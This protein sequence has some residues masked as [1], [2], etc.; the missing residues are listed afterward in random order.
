MTST[1]I[2]IVIFLSFAIACSDN[3]TGIKGSDNNNN[4][5]TV[6]ENI[7]INQTNEDKSYNQLITDNSV[8][9]IKLGMSVSDFTKIANKL[10]YTVKSEI[11]PDDAGF[12]VYDNLGNNILTVLTDAKFNE[13]LGILVN[14]GEYHTIQNIK[15]GSSVQEFVNANPKC[16]YFYPNLGDPALVT[17]NTDILFYA[18][19]ASN[20]DLS[21]ANLPETELKNA[22]NSEGVYTDKFNHEGKIKQIE[23][24]RE[25]DLDPTDFW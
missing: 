9:D 1:Y 5:I 3:K 22:K 21:L 2:K 11:N 16:K 6:G 19:D 15:V 23:I 24:G 18:T 12:L 13:I 7:T 4:N 20:N 8:G 10:K 14:S 17:I 25:I